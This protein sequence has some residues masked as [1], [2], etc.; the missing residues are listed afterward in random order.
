MLIG[1]KKAGTTALSS[2]LGE[3]PLI[4]KPAVK[5][6]LYFLPKRFERTNEIT[7]KVQIDLVRQDF[8]D[9]GNFQWQV[10]E[11]DD[12][13][14]TYEATPGY[15]FFSTLSRVPLFCTFP[16][17]KL[18]ISLRNPVDRIFSNYNFLVD[19]Q[20]K[21]K[22]RRFRAKG[23]PD[24]A[25]NATKTKAIYILNHKPVTLEEWIDM[26][27]KLLRK[28][29]VVQDEIPPQEFYGS[30]RER[31]SWS[32]YQSMV[33]TQA[34]TPLGRS[35]Y[36]LQLEEWFDGLRELGRDPESEVLVVRNED[37]KEKPDEVYQT[38]LWWLEL[39]SFKPSFYISKMVTTYRSPP[40][41]NE[42]KHMLQSFFR[43]YNQ[44]LYRLLGWD[45]V[46][47]EEYEGQH[48]EQQQE[49]EMEEEEEAQIE[50]NIDSKELAHFY[51]PPHYNETMGGAFTAKWCVLD[52]V[53]WYPPPNKQW[54]LRAPYFILPGAK[55]SGTTSL[56]SYILQH[57]FVEPART[58]E[59]Q[60]FLNK[61]FRA[62]YVNDNRQTLVREAR[63]HLY[64]LE[65]HSDELKRNAS[66]ISMDATP[67]YLFHSS[68]LPPRILCVVPWVKFVIILR[69]PV[70]RAYSNWA[71]ALRRTG[72][73]LNA[74]PFESYMQD[75]MR[76][77]QQSGFLDAA[78]PDEE[79]EPWNVYLG[80]KKE[81]PIGR[82]LYEIQL[83]QWF[84]A[85]R[86]IGRDPSTQVHI[87]RSED[88]KRDIQGEMEKVYK[89]LGLPY[90]PVASE[91]EKVVTHYSEPM[92]NKTREM[93]EEF[94]APYNKRLYD[95]LVDHG[96][97]ED[98]LGYWDQSNDLD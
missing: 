46:W 25:I 43:P 15:L 22:L 33:A 12:T 11:G 51:D 36:V 52:R 77:L 28:A 88:L 92:K 71:Y 23:V 7:Q 98:W 90:I 59:L 31:E 85:I 24:A 89:F 61:N 54:Q 95:L 47:D 2:W 41:S 60:F 84:Q 76:D 38:I 73:G 94:F 26:D 20:V 55:K 49:E 48:I 57:P 9:E 3:H 72:L 78:S 30:K 70:D 53:S 13:A 67:G 97:G 21:E 4:V 1:A 56:A 91:D 50:E 65:F 83:R 45:N 5:E 17:V 42:T 34:E 14:I 62:Q 44:R 64:T 82:S 87:V 81:G 80:H 79:I 74:I 37:M 6:L 29:G 18:L 96:F 63:E 8:Y 10:I 40:M 75:D 39:P 35:L 66:L 19:F 68:M 32:S 27:L 58:K 86:D 16:W 93:L 69:N